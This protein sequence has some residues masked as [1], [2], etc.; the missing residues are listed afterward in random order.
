MTNITTR[1]EVL[2]VSQ[3]VMTELEESGDMSAMPY[4]RVNEVL[5]MTDTHV[6]SVW[7]DGPLEGVQVANRPLAPLSEG[8]WPLGVPVVTNLDAETL[9]EQRIEQSIAEH[10]RQ[11]D[12][13]YA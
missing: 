6:I 5:I 1:P 7:N 10:D 13:E 8:P 12:A 11:M 2:E 9:E 3:A 4:Y